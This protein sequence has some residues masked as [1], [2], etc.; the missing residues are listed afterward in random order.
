V[1][2]YKSFKEIETKPIALGSLVVDGPRLGMI[3]ID[4]PGDSYSSFLINRPRREDT[5]LL[6]RLGCAWMKM[7]APKRD[8]L[9]LNFIQIR[10]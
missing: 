10:Y 2:D 3:F 8:L 4:E 9:V 7:M 1:F 6:W 5:K